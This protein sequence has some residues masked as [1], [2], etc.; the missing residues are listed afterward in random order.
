MWAIERLNEGKF[1]EGKGGTVAKRGPKRGSE[2]GKVG[3]GNNTRRVA[4]T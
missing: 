2:F 3:P 1:S 4:S